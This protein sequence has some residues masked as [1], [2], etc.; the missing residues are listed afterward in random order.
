MKKIKFILT[1]FTLGSILNVSAQSVTSIEI[2][3]DARKGG[4]AGASIGLEANA[5]SIFSNTS[6]IAFS[7]KQTAVSYGYTGWFGE[8]NLHAVGGYSKIDDKHSV[9]L[10]VRYFD[11]A[12][13]ENSSF[14]TVKPYDAIVDLGYAY[15]VTNDFAVSGNL[16]YINS[17]INSDPDINTG[18]AFA[19]D[20]GLRYQ[21]EDYAL[22]LTV[23]NLG[24][25][26]DYGIVKGDM[27]GSVNLGGAYKYVIA[28]KHKLTGSLEGAY[29]F[30]PGD[31]NTLGVGIG[32]E[33]LFNDMLAVRGGY[34]VSE[35]KKS[36]GNYGALGCGVY[37]G[38]AVIDFSYLLTEHDS[39]LKNV[40]RVS[41]GVQF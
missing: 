34:N 38:P 2:T 25:K 1:I 24:T 14:K 22:A 20:L 16:R 37:V 35:Q 32:A 27:P 26:I 23:A 29:R 15:K 18:N 7:E 9:A 40:W 5:F 31:Y 30:L 12:N 36:T 6:G 4:M 17:R 3:P 33:Y 8:N 13:F 28:P 39:I 19:F 21:K 11:A 41:V 10:G